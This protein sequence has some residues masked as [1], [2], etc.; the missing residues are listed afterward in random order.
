MA[1]VGD[2]ERLTQNSTQKKGSVLLLYVYKKY[3]FVL[4]HDPRE[5]FH[6][7]CIVYHKTKL[8]LFSPLYRN[9]W[10]LLSSEIIATRSYNAI[11]YTVCSYRR[12][13]QIN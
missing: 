8:K 2:M 5:A 1:C 11:I 10:W 7:L 6:H 13:E 12:D 4:Y 3:K 9:I